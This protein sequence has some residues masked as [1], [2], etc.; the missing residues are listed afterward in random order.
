MILINGIINLLLNRDAC[1]K[2]SWKTADRLKMAHWDGTLKVM[3]LDCILHIFNTK[4]WFRHLF[5][6]NIKWNL[7]FTLLFI[8]YIFLIIFLRSQ[9]ILAAAEGRTYI[10]SIHL[11]FYINFFHNFFSV[12]FFISK[13]FFNYCVFLSFFFLNR[14]R[15]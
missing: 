14:K 6:T 7:T 5:C 3:K 1:W 15:K 13:L 4:C 11:P 8:F 9:D 12:K 2:V 10:Y